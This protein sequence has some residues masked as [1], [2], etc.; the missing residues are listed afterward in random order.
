MGKPRGRN[1]RE[2]MSQN[3]RC[4]TN[5]CP[6]KASRLAAALVRRL[7]GDGGTWRSPSFFL[8]AFYF[9][10]G[11]RFRR[12]EAKVSIPESREFSVHSFSGPSREGLGR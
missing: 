7:V 8:L 5:P 1:E 6:A 10:C 4:S 12:A 3:F 9:P 11:L 2:L